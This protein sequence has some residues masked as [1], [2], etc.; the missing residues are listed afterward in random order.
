ML[1]NDNQ[2]IP[3]LKSM[4]SLLNKMVMEGYSANFKV[5]ENGLED[6]TS[7]KVYQPE[8]VQIKN[9]FRFEGITDPEDMAILY[10]IETNDGTRGTLVDAYGTYADA[11]INEFIKKV[12]SIHKKTTNEN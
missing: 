10:V 4:T 6:L 11:N 7:N 12:E 9:F 8:E 3:Y 5:N 2:G 1:T